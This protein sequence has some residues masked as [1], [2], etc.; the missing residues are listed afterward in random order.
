METNEIASFNHKGMVP[1]HED[2]IR[3]DE[4]DNVQA[5]KELVPDTPEWDDYYRRHPERVLKDR[6]LYALPGIL[7]RGHTLDIYAMSAVI[8][9]ATEYGLE[10]A[11]DGFVFP[12]SFHMTPERAAQKVKG[13]ARYLGA[14]MVRIGPL[15]QAYVYSHKGKTWGRS[16]DSPWGT[17][18][19][20]THK[21]AVVIVKKLDYGIIRGA[22]AQQEMMEVFRAYSQ[23]A[24]ISVSLARFIR[25]MGY[26]ARAHNLTN[27]Q[28]IIPPIAQEAGVGEL[29]RH[30]IL[31]TKEFGSSL[32]MA[33]VTTDLSMSYDETTDLG[34]DEFCRRCKICAE[35]C[36]AGAI[37]FGGKKVIRGYE[38]YPFNAEACFKFSNEVGTDCGVCMS[39]CPWG[40]PPSL[41]HSIGTWLAI[42]AGRTAVV[43]RGLVAVERLL[44]G[45]HNPGDASCPEWMEKPDATWKDYPI[46]QK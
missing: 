42:K 34:I 44:R 3:F 39:G 45:N 12:N 38:R 31:V 41:H 13:F 27:Y 40:K 37:T 35:N 17:P 24:I 21:S 8:Q 25:Q 14:D 11:V 46:W 33:V 9:T 2:R 23:L 15:N 36:P 28:V 29:G 22:P 4:R 19:N 43:A 6:E 10:S 32:K 16:D 26:P 7:G 1:S 5:R 20:L 18:I 30:G